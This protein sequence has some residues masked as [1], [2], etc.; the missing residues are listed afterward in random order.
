MNKFEVT[1]LKGKLDKSLGEF[2]TKAEA[3]KATDCGLP[4]GALIEIWKYTYSAKTPSFDPQIVSSECV[5]SFE[6]Q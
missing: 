1:A 5:E 4:K 2:D 3:I 6:V